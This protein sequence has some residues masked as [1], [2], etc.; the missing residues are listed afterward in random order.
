VRFLVNR[1]SAVNSQDRVPSPCP[2]DVIEFPVVRTPLLYAIEGGHFAVV[3]C[4]LQ[5]GASVNV[6]FEEGIGALQVAA[7]LGRQDIVRLL[8]D[9]KADPNGM[10]SIHR[11]LMGTSKIP[12]CALCHTALYYAA[13][14]GDAATTLALVEGGADADLPSP[15]GSTLLQEACSKGHEAVVKLLIEHGANIHHED[16]HKYQPIQCAALGG[17]V[18]VVS[19]LL[20]LGAKVNAAAKDGNTALHLAA[21]RGHLEVCRLLLKHGA[22]TSLRNSS[23]ELP[24]D[25]AKECRKHEIVELL[26][27][28]SAP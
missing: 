24:I 22:D 13:V 23:G 18:G 9:Y 7:L 19:L 3:Q 8:L 20:T 1:G 6:S 10:A 12:L 4:L 16:A 25:R 5:C 11:G 14:I 28:R 17:N 27:S 21:S 26:Q 15:R 2:P